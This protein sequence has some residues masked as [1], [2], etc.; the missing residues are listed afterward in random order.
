MKDFYSHLIFFKM[1]MKRLKVKYFTFEFFCSSNYFILLKLSVL[2]FLFFK[3]LVYK[4]DKIFLK[5]RNLKRLFFFYKYTDFR[6]LFLALF[7]RSNHPSLF[8]TKCLDKLF[9]FTNRT[10]L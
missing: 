6:R 4:M 1:G 8:V 9:W 7:R 5:I 3:F 2:F 10:H